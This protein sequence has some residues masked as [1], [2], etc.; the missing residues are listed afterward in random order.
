MKK[1]IKTILIMSLVAI[2][3]LF[4]LT[5]CNN[6]PYFKHLNT[7]WTEEKETA[8][9]DYKFEK[10]ETV[11]TGTLTTTIYKIADGGSKLVGG[12]EF[13]DLKG[14]SYFE[15]DLVC[16]EDIT[17]GEVCFRG[18]KKQPF[19]PI[20]SSYYQKVGED[21][22]STYIEYQDKKCIVTN[23][24]EKTELDTNGNALIFDNVQMQAIAR[25][26]NFTK[27]GTI[28]YQSPIY[29]NTVALKNVT[30]G[31]TVPA[32]VNTAKEEG[33]EPDFKFDFLTAED[34]TTGFD[35]VLVLARATDVPAGLPQT[36]LVANGNVVANGKTFAQPVLKITEGNEE[37]GL[38]TYTL[39]SLSK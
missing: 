10:G 11:K 33:K 36:M 22:R 28:Q 25:T 2:T 31:A 3:L 26:L 15:Y 27:Q 12:K 5:G 29:N 17:H 19:M 32:R 35:A 20:A 38:S 21:I 8:I 9:Y 39:T 37:K 23:N 18:T 16:G 1:S 6:T 34:G 7:N 4:S 14:A 13:T 24:G 30:I